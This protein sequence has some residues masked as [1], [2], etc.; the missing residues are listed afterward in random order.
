M[1]FFTISQNTQENTCAGVLFLTKMMAVKRTSANGWFWF[2]EIYFDNSK[3]FS[4]TENHA[5]AIRCI[6]PKFVKVHFLNFLYD[7]KDHI[8]SLKKSQIPKMSLFKSGIRVRYFT[9][10]PYCSSGI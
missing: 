5:H 4:R 10:T 3:R 8:K 7:H 2:L 1:L 6:W 9:D